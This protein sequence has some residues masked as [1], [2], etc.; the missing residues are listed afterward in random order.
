MVENGVVDLILMGCQGMVAL[1]IWFLCK[2]LLDVLPQYLKVLRPI[3]LL[4]NYFLIRYKW[5]ALAP[6]W[7]K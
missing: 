3:L 1:I 5:M 6:I 4:H 2:A 7:L